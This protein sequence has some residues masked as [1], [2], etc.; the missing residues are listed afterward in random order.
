MRLSNKEITKV[1]G[2]RPINTSENLIFNN[3]CIDS[4]KLEKDNLFIAIKGENF[5]GHDFIDD[6][7]QKGASM[8]IS[9]QHHPTYPVFVV[10]N[11]IKALGNIANYYSSLIHPVT[12]GITGTNGKTTVTNL[13]ANILKNNDKTIKTLGNYNNS[14]GLPLSIM[15]AE[16][17]TKYFVLEMGAR[18]IGDIRELTAI[19]KPNIVALLNVSPAHLDT[20]HTIENILI[21]KEEILEDQGY[22]KTV[23]LNKDAINFN[24]WHKKSNRHEIKTVSRIKDADYKVSAV[25]S[26]K[27]LLKTYRGEM[28]SINIKSS[29]DYYINNILFSVAIAIEAGASVSDVK[30]GIE[31][32]EIPPGRFTEIAGMNNCKIIDSTYNANP[33]SF[34]ASIDSLVSTSGEQIIVMG[35]MGE[36]GDDSIE[37]HL[38]VI[39]Y[40][41][42]KGIG[43]I[44]L[45][46]SFSD[47][48]KDKFD[49]NVIIFHNTNELKRLI[50]PSLN[51]KTVV[52]VKASRF[53]RFEEIIKELQSRN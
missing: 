10:D 49:K 3:I 6:A 34:K 20:F 16:E 46:Y 38:D 30:N 2:I 36:L 50:G 4:R 35:E 33:A 13:V 22:K 29:E 26:D 53:M 42:S 52:L 51:S 8:A 28:I 17:N 44:F 45:K 7:F 43:K 23:I 14:I 31:S 25:S 9:E 41:I 39:S 21:T 32:F 48:I 37:H 12:I 24:R 27:L 1:L 47:K 40:A 19:A 15:K 18:K 5:N 11:T